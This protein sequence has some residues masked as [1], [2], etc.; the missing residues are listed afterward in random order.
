MTAYTFPLNTHLFDLFG[1]TVN[2][3]DYVASNG[4]IINELK[5]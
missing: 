1:D 5:I 3:S 4:R 2:S